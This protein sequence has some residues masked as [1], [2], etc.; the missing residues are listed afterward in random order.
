MNISE[1]FSEV[2]RTGAVVQMVGAP[3][4]LYMTVR[5][6]FVNHSGES[7]VT[8]IWFDTTA[9]LQEATFPE[10]ILRLRRKADAEYE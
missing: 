8:C 1:V 10:R 7:M 5:R 2:C 6:Q 3:T 4:N 9:R